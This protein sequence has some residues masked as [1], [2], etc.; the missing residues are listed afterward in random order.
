MAQQ[1][2]I[3][4]FTGNTP[5]RVFY[6]NYDG[7]GCVLVGTYSSTPL[8]FIVPS[9]LAEDN[10]LIKIIDNALCEVV[11]YVINVTLTPTPTN[12]STPT[13]T[14]T[15]TPPAT[16]SVTPTN[17]PTQTNTPGLSATPTQTPTT[18]QTP[19]NTPSTTPPC[20]AAD[21]RLLNETG[22]SLSWTALTCNGVGV[23]G[24]ILGGQQAD[25]G[26]IRVGTLSEG[27]LTIVS[28]TPC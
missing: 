3:D 18:T 5:F 19:T 12:T 28:S 26:C 24:T 7:T 9:P 22:G 11:K 17:T 1:I 8:N 4:S 23:G 15:S 2:T 13:P 10:Y 20:E 27:S 25:T 6:C 16:P 14:T 21:Y